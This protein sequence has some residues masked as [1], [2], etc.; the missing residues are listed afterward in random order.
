MAASHADRNRFRPNQ[1]CLGGEKTST[2]SVSSSATARCGRLLG[3]DDRLGGPQGVGL[4]IR[5]AEAEVAPHTLE[6]V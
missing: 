2:S 5:G 1:S 3:I 6:D 4:L